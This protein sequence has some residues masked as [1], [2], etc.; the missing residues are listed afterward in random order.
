M[1]I[2]TRSFVTLICVAFLTAFASAQSSVSQDFG[3]GVKG[4]FLGGG[5]EAAM[6]M[7]HRTNVR[8][9]FNILGYSRGFDKDGVD[10]AGH[11]GFKTVEAHYDFFPF[12]GSFHLSPGVLTYIGNP[13]TANASVPG[14]QSFTLG[15][16]TY[17]SDATTPVTGNGKIDF[18]RVAPMATVGFGNLIPR[19][20]SKHFSLPVELGVAF[21]GTPK[22]NLNLAGNVCAAPGLDCR[23]IAGD[24]TV[25]ANILAEQTKINNSMSL[26]KAYPII[27][28]GM[29][30]KF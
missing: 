7:T 13:I 9:G 14:G 28:V 20:E 27:S 1:P 22:A 24:P 16:Q 21:Q 6:L 30:Y 17:Y 8:A 18:D 2:Q 10:Y 5:V 11:V 25:Q 15:G 23:S 29:G 26:F 19:K 4:S 12:A 3:I